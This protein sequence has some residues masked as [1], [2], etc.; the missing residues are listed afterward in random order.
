MCPGQSRAGTA[1][2]RYMLYSRLYRGC[3]W[4]HRS[5]SWSDSS[6]YTLWDREGARLPSPGVVETLLR[7]KRDGVAMLPQNL[8]KETQYCGTD[9][10]LG[11][12]LV[13][14]VRSDEENVA[15]KLNIVYFTFT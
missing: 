3:T 9:H 8:D 7:D 14:T 12:V 4:S 1:S 10:T 2:C 13:A 6:V 11:Y 5:I 15:P